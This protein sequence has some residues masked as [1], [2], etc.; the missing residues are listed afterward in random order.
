MNNVSGVTFS[1]LPKSELDCLKISNSFC[2][3]IIS[4]QG[5]QILEFFSKVKGK[6]LLWVSDLNL[7][8]SGKAIR[9]GIPVCFPWFGASTEN[10]DFP[11]HGFARN[12]VW[13]LLEVSVDERGH[14]VVFELNDNHDT[15]KYWNFAF[16]LQMTIHCGQ[17]LQLELKLVNRDKVEIECDFVWHSYFSANTKIAQVQGLVKMEYIDQLDG[18]K[19]K[20]QKNQKI[21]FAQEED[22]IYSKGVGQLELLQNGLECIRIKTNAM[23]TVIWN[24]WVDKSI[25][26]HDV[27]NDS[28]QNF[29]CIECGQI[30]T[31]KIKLKSTESAYYYLYI[32]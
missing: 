1:K 22:R 25:R 26:L 2:D 4:F 9:G 16:S 27:R 3:A 15:R 5:A 30:G 17:Q 21:V 12:L 7:Y 10:K 23:S 24:P 18:N 19:L 31:E 28:W 11:S 32:T 29:V 8:S 6:P 14:H 13:R 20:I